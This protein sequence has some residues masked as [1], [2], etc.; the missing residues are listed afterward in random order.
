MSPQTT[1][2]EVAAEDSASVSLR[3]LLA[4]LR[5]LGVTELHIAHVCREFGLLVVLSRVLAGLAAAS[6]AGAL[7]VRYRGRD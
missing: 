2:L 6:P 1:P 5:V 4:L 7:G 3:R